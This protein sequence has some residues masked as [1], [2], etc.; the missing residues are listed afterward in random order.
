MIVWRETDKGDARCRRLADRHYT[1]QRPGHPMWTRPG[2]NMVLYTSDECGE[3]CFAWWRPKWED[4]IERFDG[5]RALECT[6]FRNETGWLSSS[7]IEQAVAAVQC[8][9]RYEPGSSLITGIGSLQTQ[10][11][12]SRNNRPGHCFR[13]A[14]WEDFEHARG[15]ADVWLMCKRFPAAE[16]AVRD[17]GGQLALVGLP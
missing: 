2:Y 6:L 7:L 5:L 13:V 12:R 1:R 14:G 17:D 15:R 4:G 9:E 3:A 8:W 10:R 11:R 16:V